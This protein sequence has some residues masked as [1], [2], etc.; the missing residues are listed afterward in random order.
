MIYP[1]RSEEHRN[2][3]KAFWHAVDSAP[4]QFRAKLAMR[5]ALQNASDTSPDETG[6]WCCAVTTFDMVYDSIAEFHPQHY[7][8]VWRDGARKATRVRK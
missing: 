2:Y 6:F 8:M 7:K 1:V 3:E 4:D 5:S